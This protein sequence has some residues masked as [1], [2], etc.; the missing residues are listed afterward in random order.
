[1]L[2]ALFWKDDHTHTCSHSPKDAEFISK[3]K[4]I[5]GILATPLLLVF[6]VVCHKADPDLLQGNLA[7]PCPLVTLGAI[8]FQ[9]TD[10]AWPKSQG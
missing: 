9:L 4:K 6:Q 1:M 2:F 3:A 7:F 5:R 10:G 8:I